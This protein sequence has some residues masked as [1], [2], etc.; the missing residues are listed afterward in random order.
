M[1]LST[2]NKSVSVFP[3][4]VVDQNHFVTMRE[5]GG[6]VRVTVRLREK[7]GVKGLPTAI[8]ALLRSAT[9]VATVSW[10]VATDGRTDGRNARPPAP[11]PPP[12]WLMNALSASVAEKRRRRWTDSR[13]VGDRKYG[14]Q[15]FAGVVQ[16]P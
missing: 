5:E 13:A 12:A 2:L 1:Q 15:V 16:S 10:D 11:P 14:G 3:G 6:W 4:C 9:V 8:D 7:G